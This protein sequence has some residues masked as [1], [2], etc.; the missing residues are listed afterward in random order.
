MWWLGPGFKPFSVFFPKSA[1]ETSHFTAL[2]MLY[3][4]IEP[5]YSNRKCDLDCCEPRPKYA[6]RCPD[7]TS[8]WDLSRYAD[9]PVHQQTSS[10]LQFDEQL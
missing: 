9:R 4:F 3:L 8:H 1:C 2:V 10:F 7:A 5:I 6:Q